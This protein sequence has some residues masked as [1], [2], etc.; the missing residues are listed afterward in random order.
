MIIEKLN[1]TE[2]NFFDESPVSESDVAT[3]FK[4]VNIIYG[5]NGAGK[6]TISSY[7]KNKY[8]AL[9][10]NRDYIL[11]NAYFETSKELKGVKLVSG[12]KNLSYEKKKKEHKVIIDVLSSELDGN[13]IKISDMENQI[14][15]NMNE[16]Y[17]KN[18][19]GT[20]VKNFISL[21]DAKEHLNKSTIDISRYD[22][23]NINN[24][25]YDE[26]NKFDRV[27]LI[28]YNINPK[29]LTIFETH[30]EKKTFSYADFDWMKKG[31]TYISGN[32][33]GFCGNVVSASKIEEINNYMYLS[34]QN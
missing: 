21:I 7:L 31:M 2:I 4:S 23:N 12:E 18:K 9:V 10:Y 15:Y 20:R 26:N 19:N 33:C 1:E 24:S 14:Q 25:L 5:E 6:S 17:E 29:I 34:T 11:E 28:N 32:T 16:I 30:Y 8:G 13:K 27:N 3:K 22:V